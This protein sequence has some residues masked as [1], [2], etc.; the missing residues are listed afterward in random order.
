MSPKVIRKCSFWPQRFDI[1][2]V[3]NDYTR[4]VVSKARY[5]TYLDQQQLSLGSNASAYSD[6]LHAN[7][8]TP[9]GL[10]LTKRRA[11][12]LYREMCN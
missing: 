12:N 2:K 4:L 5:T 1:I 7:V 8:S 11:V 9:D 3:I 6:D 10:S